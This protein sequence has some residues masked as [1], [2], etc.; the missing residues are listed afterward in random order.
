[1]ALG[2]LGVH[3][4]IGESALYSY[5]AQWWIDIIGF[6]FLTLTGVRLYR[7][8]LWAAKVTVFLLYALF[9]LV[10]ILIA[11]CFDDYYANWAYWSLPLSLP[12]LG[13]CVHVLRKHRGAFVN[14]L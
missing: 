8:R 7:M 6:S 14:R 4:A 5:A 10:L 2:A 11:V 9:F 12:L 13:S 3:A 1:M